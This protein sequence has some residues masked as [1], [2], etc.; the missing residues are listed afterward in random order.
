MRMKGRMMT[1]IIFLIGFALCC[2]P[3]VSSI[4]ERQYQKGA[5]STYQNAVEEKDT[6]EIENTIKNAEEY[7][8]MLYQSKGAVVA[9]LQEGILS[10]ESYNNQL[11]TSGAGVMG[12]IEIPKINVDLPIYHGTSD[13]V[14]T[15][16]V[17]HLEGT[18]LPVGGA[19]TRCVLTGHRGLP[20]SKLFTRL[21]E[22]EEGDLFFISTCGE[23]LAYKVTTIEVIEPEDVDRLEIQADKDLVSLI[24]CTPFGINTHRLVV[25]GERVPYEKSDYTSIKSSMPSWREILFAVLPFIFVFIVVVNYIRDRR[26]KKREKVNKK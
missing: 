24:T 13:E 16:G 18:S 15:N 8:S 20:N 25:T 3:L 1:R 10:E 6:S 23:I 22:V 9:D 5:V 4:I 7:N 26:A 12:S 11:N 21:D 19:S 2:Y 14:L 17:G